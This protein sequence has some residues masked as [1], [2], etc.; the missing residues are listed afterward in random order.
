MKSL[1]AS[2][3]CMLIV[4]LAS[5]AVMA[6]TPKQSIEH[7]DLKTGKL[8]WDLDGEVRLRYIPNCQA[9]RNY[10]DTVYEL[11]RELDPF[12]ILDYS[13]RPYIVSCK[14][15][16]LRVTYRLREDEMFPEAYGKAI[17]INDK[18]IKYYTESFEIIK[19]R[20]DS[21]NYQNIYAALQAQKPIVAA[22]YR[23]S[24]F[25]TLNHVIGYREKPEAQV[26]INASTLD[27]ADRIN[28]NLAS[29]EAKQRNNKIYHKYWVVLFLDVALLSLLVFGLFLI[30][31]WILC[32]SRASFE[33]ISTYKA[34]FKTP[35]LEFLK[36]IKPKRSTII[37]TDN[38]K[39]YSVAVE[40]LKWAQLK[41]AGVVSEEEFQ[42]ARRKI[43]S[44]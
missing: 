12:S 18:I 7:F 30:R 2:V 34:R 37:K 25:E 23:N 29:V 33:K 19:D 10:A 1:P 13:G 32:S 14:K 21:D 28:A 22:V 43:M 44:K 36:I 4:S 41:E 11:M 26:V 6:A 24:Y 27:E 31:R 17:T 9:D 40:L 16:G 20:S 5:C 35:A 38:L 3:V 8:Y 15:R 42:D 39:T